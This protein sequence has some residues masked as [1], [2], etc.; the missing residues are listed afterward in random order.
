[1]GAS[2]DEETAISE[3]NITPLVDVCL[4]LVIIFMVTS[5]MVVQSGIVVNSSKV[6]ESVGKSTKDEAVQIKVTSKAVYINNKKVADES[7][8]PA[9]KAALDANK[10]KVTMITSDRDAIHG[11]LVNVLDMAKK[12]GAK[13]LTIMREDKKKGAAA[14][15]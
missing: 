8:Y 11:R 9:L 2:A 7:V 1:M 4:V 6:T 15:E 12:A 5:P 14:S 13:S 10:K 3:I